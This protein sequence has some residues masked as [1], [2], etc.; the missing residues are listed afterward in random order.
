M[1]R[2]KRYACLLALAGWLASA[3][4]AIEAPSGFVARGTAW[5]TP[6]YL[7]DSG[8]PGPCV[9]I[10]A[11]IHGNEPAGP[12]AA[13]Q[14]RCWPIV[15]GRLVVVPRANLVAL[16]AGSRLLRSNDGTN[17][18]DL[19]RAFPPERA[20]KETARGL[21]IALWDFVRSQKPDWLLD[22][23]EGG[24][25]RVQTNRSVGSSIIPCDMAEA[26]QS[27]ATMLDA[28]NRS[29]TD[30]NRRFVLLDHPRKGTLVQ[31]AADQLG[32]PSLIVETTRQ[33]QPLSLR[34]RQHRIAVHAF[35]REQRMLPASATTE[36][37]LPVEPR[38]GL[39]AVA[40][41]DGGG[42][43]GKG[44]PAVLA[45]LGAETNFTTMRLCPEDIRAGALDQFDV[46]MFTGGSGSGQASALGETGR[47]QVKQFVEK[48]G[49]YVGICA[50][51]YLACSGFTWGL[52]I[53]NAKTLSPLWRR[54]TDIVK[55]E[56]TNRG[57][58]ILDPR[59]GQLDCLY[60]QGPILGPAGAPGLPDFEPLAFFRTEVA[61]NNTPKGLMVDSPAI[62]ASRFGNGRVLCFSPHPEQSQGLQVL[63]TRAVAWVASRPSLGTPK[64]VKNAS[65]VGS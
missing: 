29:V 2:E 57:R 10:I 37:M 62:L 8:T 21:A 24:N 35:L 4:G 42:A 26:R 19:N 18:L 5:E 23:H 9:L 59:Q 44:V 47:R 32:L 14:I 17:G 64:P 41:Y 16:R 31:A 13:D 52:G 40:V 1:N 61:R 7:H 55:I 48:G 27:A 28:L 34:A 49:G 60:F 11:G 43:T 15:R 45:L 51:S 53:L 63:L 50:G 25:F 38:A 12:C 36:R 56:L 3:G 20:P 6:Y 33:S 46:V 54:G 30:N 22:L 65:R 39:T 58:E